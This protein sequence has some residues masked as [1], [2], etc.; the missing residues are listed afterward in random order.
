MSDRLDDYFDCEGLRPTP[1]PTPAP[2]PEPTPVPTAR[3]TPAPT[4]LSPSTVP[5]TSPAPSALK[6][7]ITIRIQTDR[8]PEEVGWSIVDFDTNEVINSTAIGGYKG[9]E[10]DSIIEEVIEVDANKMFTL[11]IE[12]RATDGMCCFWGNGNIAV[13]LGATSDPTQTLAYH[14]GE[15]TD[16]VDMLI[17]TSEVDAFDSQP[18]SPTPPQATPTFAPTR[19]GDCSLLSPDGCSVCGNLD[20]CIQKPDAIV[21]SPN[22]P[23]VTCADLEKAGREGIIPS[24]ECVALPDTIRDLCACAIPTAAPTSSPS[25]SPEPT[26]SPTSSMKP[27]ASPTA[28]PAPSFIDEREFLLVFST[29]DHPEESS[30]SVQQMGG[31][32]VQNIVFGDLTDTRSDTSYLINL[33]VGTEYTLIA[34]DKFADG[35]CKYEYEKVKGQLLQPIRTN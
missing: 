26:R 5:T 25:I 7:F 9:Y 6:T 12:D 3:P 27:S 34:Y 17:S 32:V 35:N 24:D 2:T 13:Y 10:P 33:V 16:K 8:Y 14:N 18:P 11:T 22:E 1:A 30:W 15:Y 20:H 29:D 4:T 19:A 28:S 23:N 21:S 31:A